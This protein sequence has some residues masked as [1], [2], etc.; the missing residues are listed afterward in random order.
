MILAINKSLVLAE[1]RIN[2]SH[3]KTRNEV[4][5][6]LGLEAVPGGDSS[7]SLKTNRRKRNR[8]RRK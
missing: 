6:E 2:S 5:L 4:R 8:E 7:L 3:L 1:N